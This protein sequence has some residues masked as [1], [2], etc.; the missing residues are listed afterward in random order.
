MYGVIESVDH[1]E[2]T[3]HVQWFK[4]SPENPS[5]YENIKPKLPKTCPQ[6]LHY[7]FSG[8]ILLTKLIL[9]CMIYVIILI[10]NLNLVV[11]LYILAQ[12]QIQ[13]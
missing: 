3:A 8:Q 5:L 6:S 4:V 2:R 10:F 12:K 11:L 1:A 13:I 9:V 7:Y